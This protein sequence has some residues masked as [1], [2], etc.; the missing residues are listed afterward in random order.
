M[1]NNCKQ[2]TPF[3]EDKQQKVCAVKFYH[4]HFL[5]Y[6]VLS[7]SLVSALTIPGPNCRPRDSRLLLRHGIVS[8][9][10]FAHSRLLKKER[11]GGGEQGGILRQT[12]RR[13]RSIPT[14]GLQRCTQCLHVSR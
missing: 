14:P 5:L 2:S 10:G 9:V 3:Q 12:F 13:K 4:P 6:K 11:R 7:L 1:R 8:P